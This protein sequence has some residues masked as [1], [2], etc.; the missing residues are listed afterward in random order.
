MSKVLL[1]K[2]GVSTFDVDTSEC[3]DRLFRNVFYTGVLDMSEG[4]SASLAE[5]LDAVIDSIA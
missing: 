5:D 2:I 1:P 3:E 4:Y